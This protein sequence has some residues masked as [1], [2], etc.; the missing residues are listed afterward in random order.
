MLGIALAVANSR[1]PPPPPE[2]PDPERLLKGYR[3][4]ASRITKADMMRL[5]ILREQTGE[6]ISQLLHEAVSAYYDM[7]MADEPSPDDNGQSHDPALVTQGKP[8]EEALP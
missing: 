2:P 4:P 5:T 8:A 6:P 1:P 3:W 7:L